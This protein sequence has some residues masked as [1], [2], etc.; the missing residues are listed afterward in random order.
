MARLDY[1]V[2][3]APS[4]PA[5]GWSIYGAERTQPTAIGGKPTCSDNRSTKPIRNR[6]QPFAIVRDLMVRRGSTVSS[7]PEGSAEAPEIGSFSFR[8]TCSVSN[9]RWVWSRLG[10]FA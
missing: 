2:D 3:V 5:L 7:P 8:S 4:K 10:S 1:S 9:V 6:G